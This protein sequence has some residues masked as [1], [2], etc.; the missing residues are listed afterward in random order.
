M[1]SMT[2][3]MRCEVGRLSRRE[4]RPSPGLPVA[5]TISQA[6]GSGVGAPLPRSISTAAGPRSRSMSAAVAGA[7]AAAPPPR[8]PTSRAAAPPTR[9]RPPPPPASASPFPARAAAATPAMRLS[10]SRAEA[11]TAV[12]ATDFSLPIGRLLT[13][14]SAARP[15]V[16]QKG[17]RIMATAHADPRRPPSRPVE[18]QDP[19]NRFVYHPLAARLARLLVP[20]GI[21]PN[22][23]SVGSALCLLA[24]TWC[25]VALAPPANWSAGL[26]FMLLWHVVDGADGDLARMTARTSAT[27]ELVDGACDIFGNTVMYFAFAFWLDDTMR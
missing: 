11:K 18:R 5:R 2:R 23:I 13:A 21:T 20:T 7:S 8:R 22:M 9:T 12:S 17:G 14:R 10:A 25:F 26:F 6:E 1:A 27:G 3:G 4:P 16:D 15:L 24:A 19:L